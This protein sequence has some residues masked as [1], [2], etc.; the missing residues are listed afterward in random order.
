MNKK[1]RFTIIFASLIPLIFFLNS[2]VFARTYQILHMSHIAWSSANVADVKG[3][4]KAE[5]IDVDVRVYLT[6][7]DIIN[8]IKHQQGDFYLSNLPVLLNELNNQSVFLGTVGHWSGGYAFVIKKEMVGKSLQGLNVG[9]VGGDTPGKIVLN[10]YLKTLGDDKKQIRILPL[11]NDV[12][13]NNFISGRLQ[14]V[15]VQERSVKAL[16]DQEGIV[17]QRSPLISLGVGSYL[18][19]LKTVPEKDLDKLYRGWI[20]ARL[21]AAKAENWEEYKKII[22]KIT[23]KNSIQVS[24]EEIVTELSALR[25]FD[26]AS[27]LKDNQDLTDKSMKGLIFNQLSEDLSGTEKVVQNKPAMA[28]LKEYLPIVEN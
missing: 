9:I 13:V 20:E 7:H 5:G 10:S 26:A 16:L 17:V 12:L 18:S 22:R 23:L 24:D 3:F 8:A 4:W 11:D 14:A 19:T 1:M 25:P 6:T 15:I 21:W 27:L 2:F 28:V